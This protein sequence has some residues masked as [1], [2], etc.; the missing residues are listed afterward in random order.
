MK[1]VKTIHSVYQLMVLPI[2]QSQPLILPARLF[3]HKNKCLFI[4]VYNVSAESQLQKL[5]KDLRIFY[6]YTHL[7]IIYVGEACV[8]VEDVVVNDLSYSSFIRRRK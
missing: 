3:I 8:A 2:S 6:R 7:Y 1:K 5:L 4:L